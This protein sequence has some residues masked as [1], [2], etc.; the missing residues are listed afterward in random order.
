MKAVKGIYKDG[1]VTLTEPHP[2]HQKS[3]VIV[4]FMDVLQDKE[5]KKTFSFNKARELSKS[6]KGSLADALLEERER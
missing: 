1:K 2:L 3:E 6:F 5:E 4:I